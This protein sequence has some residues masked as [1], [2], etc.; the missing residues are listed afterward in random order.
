M[1]H[2]RDAMG[3]ETPNSEV[4]KIARSL[5][6]DDS[7]A[8]QNPQEI[9]QISP[10]NP[11][12]EDSVDKNELVYKINARNSKLKTIQILWISMVGVTFTLAILQLF[13]YVKAL[14]VKE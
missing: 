4:F 14:S 9:I 11:A 2:S 6:S 1:V 7:G 10:N 3:S 8:P 12:K 5:K 13:F